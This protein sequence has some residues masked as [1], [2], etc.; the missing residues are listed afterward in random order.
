MEIVKFILGFFDKTNLDLLFTGIL[1]FCTII[2]AISTVIMCLIYFRIANMMQKTND[3]SERMI[4]E[5][6]RNRQS[7]FAPLIIKVNIGGKGNPT[8]S[9]IITIWLQN[10]G[11]GSAI[12]IKVTFGNRKL[13]KPSIINF[14]VIDKNEK[15]KCEFSIPNNYNTDVKAEFKQSKLDIEYNDIFQNCYQTLYLNGVGARIVR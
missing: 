10:V 5:T 11:V 3:I 8:E 6:T 15:I 9:G 2:L 13:R 14:P 1:A 7:Q 4:L 12:G